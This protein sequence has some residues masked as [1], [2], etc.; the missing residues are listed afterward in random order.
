MN[1]IFE[2]YIILFISE[3]L[4]ANLEA[5]RQT[6]KTLTYRPCKVPEFQESRN[7]CAAA[8]TL[9]TKN[10]FGIIIIIYDYDQTREIKWLYRR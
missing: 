4:F 5:C 1:F 3:Y 10:V 2:I 7:I 9:R 8:S 6:S